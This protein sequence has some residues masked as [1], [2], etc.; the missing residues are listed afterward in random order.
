MLSYSAPGY[1]C[2][3]ERE[4]VSQQICDSF[5]QKV[6]LASLV[7]GRHT[8]MILWQILK[9]LVRLSIV[10]TYRVLSCQFSTVCSGNLAYLEG[11][12]SVRD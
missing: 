8:S 12:V 7:Y 5:A 9:D 11:E 3:E 2:R 1:A 6:Q 10:V 4:Q